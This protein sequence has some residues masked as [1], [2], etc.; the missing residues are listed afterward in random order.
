MAELPELTNETAQTWFAAELP[1]LF[2]EL[3]VLIDRDEIMVTG[4][5]R[6]S[7]SADEAGV[8]DGASDPGDGRVE[9]G[10]LDDIATFRE[11][12]RGDRVEVARRAEAK[13]RRKVSWGAKCGSTDA[14]FT[15]QSVPVMT[16]LRL[17]ERHVLDTLVAAGVA[18][19][20]SDA[21][22][23]C[24]RRM[25]EQ[26]SGWLA[27]LRNAIAGVDKARATRP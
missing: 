22:G 14:L 6:R 7:T 2:S 27:D 23:W 24:V 20:R 16:R 13:F 10:E 25:A 9:R 3:E 4:E 26:E 8:D 21:L 17:D 12:S 18:R 11:E 5:I 19:S 1:D 15:H